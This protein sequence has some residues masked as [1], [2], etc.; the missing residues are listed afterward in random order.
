MPVTAADVQRLIVLKVGDVD[1]A[2]GDPP[3]AGGAGMIASNITTLWAARADKAY[4]APRLQELY[5]QR[6][7]L[8]LVIGILRHYV[9]ITQGDPA[10]S[11][12]QSQRAV[13]AQQQRDAIQAEIEVVERRAIA[14]TGGAGVAL[15]P[16]TTTAPVAP[17]DDASRPLTLTPDPNDPV[18]GGTPYRPSRRVR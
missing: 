6:D 3:L 10:L 1:P 5:V 15:G 8:E 9:D 14:S 2:T 13:V 12:K 17:A 18:Y 11:A 4:A 16:I 7:A